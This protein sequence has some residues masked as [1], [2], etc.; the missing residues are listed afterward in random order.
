MAAIKSLQALADIME[1]S[2]LENYFM[3]LIGN[4][5]TDDKCAKRWSVC[6]LF[7]TVYL[8]VSPKQQGKTEEFSFYYV[9]LFYY[10]TYCIGNV[11]YVGDLINYHCIL[12]F[13]SMSSVRQDAARILVDLSQVV[14]LSV[15]NSKL[16]PRLEQFSFDKNVIL[17]DV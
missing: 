16:I 17:Y 14:H 9:F 6:H 8:R 15:F 5:T 1:V 13:D 4:M 7:T 3:P 2:D 12:C 11:L 10:N